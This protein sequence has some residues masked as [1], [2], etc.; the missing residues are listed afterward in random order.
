VQWPDEQGITLGSLYD[1]PEIHDCHL[2]AHVAHNP[3]IVG[4][5]EV[6]QAKLAL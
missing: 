2:I 3:Q 6:A 4:N 1:A 5:K